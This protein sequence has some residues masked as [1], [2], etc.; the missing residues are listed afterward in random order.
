MPSTL[1][2]ERLRL[3]EV[4]HDARAVAGLDHVEAAQGGLVDRP[5]RGA[6]AVAGVEEVERD[7]RRARDGEAGGRIGGRRSSRLN[8]TMVLP[9][10]PFDTVSDSMLLAACAEGGGRERQGQRGGEP[11]ERPAGRS[12]GDR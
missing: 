8:L 3:V 10:V 12:P 4:E 9:E 2:R 5:L 6:E 7:A 1:R 11:R